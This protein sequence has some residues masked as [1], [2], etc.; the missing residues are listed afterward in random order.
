MRRTLSLVL[1]HLSAALLPAEQVTW[2]RGNTHSHSLQ[3]DGDVRADRV[4]EIYRRLGYDFLVLTDHNWVTQLD[5]EPTRENYGM[6]VIRGEECDSWGGPGHPGIHTTGAN[7]SEDIPAQIGEMPDA[8]ARRLARQLQAAGISDESIERTLMLERSTAILRGAVAAIRRQRGVPILNHPYGGPFEE[9]IRRCPDLKLVE[10]WNQY[11]NLRH[12]HQYAESMWDA[13]LTSGRRI[14]AVA[15][16]DSHDM[17][18]TTDTNRAAGATP[19]RGWVMVRASELTPDAVLGAMERGDFYSST[20]VT[21]SALELG[22]R[23]V[24]VAVRE[25]ASN[26]Y[27][28]E[29]I[30]AG[31]V[32]LSR[33][34]GTQARYLISGS[35]RY[36]RVRIRDDK[37]AFAWT[38]PVFIANAPAGK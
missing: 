1:L 13:L 9:L 27:V 30:G 4:V 2:Y 26:S 32:V 15:S 18:P 28:I 36:V 10:I 17:D 3:S 22:P 31:G 37:G 14:Y 20:G 21:L 34:R 38:Q 23:E 24:K 5:R 25:S 11:P 8:K 12:H 19:G 6:L 29:F 7:L 35:D 33:A 16:D